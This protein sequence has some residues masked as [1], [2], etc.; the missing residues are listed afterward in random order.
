MKIKVRFKIYQRRKKRV[1]IHKKS[2]IFSYIVSFIMIFTMINFSNYAQGEELKD[3]NVEIVKNNKA[4][5]DNNDNLPQLTLDKVENTTGQSI[6][7]EIKNI[8]SQ[9]SFKIGSDAVVGIN[10]K[11]N[12]EEEK[13]VTLIVVLYDKN[14]N[15]EKYVHQYKNVKKGENLNMECTINIPMDDGYKLKAFVWNNLD[16][17]KPLYKDLKFQIYK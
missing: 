12:T 15:L 7:L 17:I 11:N 4:Y 16:D 6:S 2:R 14:D 1:R 13:E 3:V 8:T 10:V 9:N 5:D